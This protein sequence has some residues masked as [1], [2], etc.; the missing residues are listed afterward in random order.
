M[1]ADRIDV[2]RIKKEPVD[3]D[4]P[5]PP[6]LMNQKLTE[7]FKQNGINS[8]IKTNSN[9]GK[10]DSVK[11]KDGEMY[12]V[13]EG[14]DLSG[15]DESNTSLSDDN[16]L[17]C[18]VPKA[19][20]QNL[21]K[22][23]DNG[24]SEVKNSVLKTILSN[25]PNFDKLSKDDCDK[26]NNSEQNNAEFEPYLYNDS[27]V[28]GH[29]IPNRIEPK[30]K[31]IH[32][33]SL[34]S[35][36][37]KKKT[38]TSS[39]KELTT[40]KSTEKILKENEI[41]KEPITLHEDKDIGEEKKELDRLIKDEVMAGLIK[42]E[43]APPE[44][45]DFSQVPD[46]P[47]LAT[48]HSE[49]NQYMKSYMHSEVRIHFRGEH[50]GEM[51][52]CQYCDREFLRYSNKMRHERIHLGIRPHECDVCGEKFFQRTELRDHKYKHEGIFPFPCDLCEKQFRK[53]S[54]FNM[55]RKIHTGEG[56]VECV[57]C[58]KKFNYKSS[59]TKHC[60]SERH[61]KQEAIFNGTVIKK[62][63]I[64]SKK[65]MKSKKK[66]IRD[67]TESE[68]N[69]DEIEDESIDEEYMYNENYENSNADEKNYDSHVDETNFKN[70]DKGDDSSD[71]TI[72][73]NYTSSLKEDKLKGGNAG[74]KLIIKRK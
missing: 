67:D 21:N 16:Y 35:R 14:R 17:P 12:L 31:I 59:Y 22:S 58:N 42:T 56:I 19:N 57:P 43:L 55:H 7:A 28:F 37:K 70:I 68:D 6:D 38:N 8:I 34:S 30:K 63:N 3:S 13:N 5:V 32:K 41:K 36:G 48:T 15:K 54:Q 73:E 64:A 69:T 40:V 39:K 72:D 20:E 26:T 24:T 23:V 1:M 11:R 44:P 61:H 71:T 52:N 66:W 62:N 9:K 50:G 47:E 2:V 49:A 29:K 45:F 74:M 10:Q 18:K 4:I 33:K 46:L 25:E 53:R 27:E 60:E 51:Y 65:K